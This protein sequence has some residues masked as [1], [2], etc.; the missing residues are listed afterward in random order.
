M[1]LLQR[2]FHNSWMMEFEILKKVQIMMTRMRTMKT[3]SVHKH[4][5]LHYPLDLAKTEQLMMSL[6][7]V[8]RD[9]DHENSRLGWL[10][11]EISQVD[12]FNTPGHTARAFPTLYPWGIANLNEPRVREIKPADDVK[13]RRNI[14][15]MRTI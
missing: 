2:N 13:S 6:N 15:Y 11:N 10:H 1:A 5:F 8:Q 12:E 9:R 4:L 14:I 7:R 3:L